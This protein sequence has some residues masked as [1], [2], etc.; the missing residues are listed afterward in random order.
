MGRVEELAAE[1]ERHI[2]I[3]WQRTV[4]GAQRVVMVVYEKELERTL[5]ARIGEFE[6]RTRS[7]GHAWERYDC[8]H[9]FSEWVAGAEYR[10]AYFEAPEDLQMKLEGEFLDHVVGPLRDLLQ[11]ADENTVVAVTGVASLYGFVRVSEVIRAVEPDIQGR[12]V[13]FFPGSKDGDRYRLLDA[14]D[15]WNYLANGITL[16]GAG[17]RR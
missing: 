2:C 8:T 14:R 10:D 1:Y 4:A 9:L 7:S 15:G 5:R 6:Q 3:P 13:V 17:G 16:H 12:L 11:E